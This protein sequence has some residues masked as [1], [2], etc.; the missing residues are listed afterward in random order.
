LKRVIQ[1]QDQ[2]II[3]LDARNKELENSLNSTVKRR[4]Q[5]EVVL[6]GSTF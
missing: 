3:A 2:T 6:D 1:Q 4:K 5:K